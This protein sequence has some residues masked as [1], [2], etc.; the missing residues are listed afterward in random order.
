MKKVQWVRTT[1]RSVTHNISTT[2]FEESGLLP[3]PMVTVL[4]CDI[5]DE[6]SLNEPEADILPRG[7]CH[8]Y[9]WRTHLSESRR[10]A[11]TVGIGLSL[12]DSHENQDQSAWPLTALPAMNIVQYQI[13]CVWQKKFGKR[14]LIQGVVHYGSLKWN[15]STLSAGSSPED[16]CAHC[17]V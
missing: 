16:S 10:E 5:K 17:T 15:L 4:K 3:I 9:P 2:L 8:T 11:A 12:R 14:D 7:T 13:L 6:F 1:R